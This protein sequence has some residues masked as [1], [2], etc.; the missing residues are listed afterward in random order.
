MK[1]EEACVT[2]RFPNMEKA[3]EI[4]IFQDLTSQIRGY[5][6]TK[7]EIGMIK[8]EKHSGNY[9]VY[10]LIGT[11]KSVY[12]GQSE[13]GIKRIEDHTRNKNFWTHCL[14]FVT[15]NN[16]FDKTSIDYLEN[17]FIKKFNQSE[18]TLENALVMDK[19]THT[20]DFET[21]RYKN[22][23]KHIERLLLCNGIKIENKTELEKRVGL[24]NNNITSHHFKNKK[25]TASIVLLDGSFILKEGSE[26]REPEELK[27]IMS[28]NNSSE[29]TNYMKNNTIKKI[30]QLIECGMAKRENGKIVTKEDIIFGS[31]SGPAR[32][33]TG[34]PDNGWDYWVGLSEFRDKETFV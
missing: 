34:N 30:E 16:T 15:D 18:Y 26:L 12:I 8:Q 29:N 3:D 1:Y 33:I 24:K 11:E 23:S 10:F 19:T 7:S 5:Y 22:L 31:P 13:N 14:M 2:F 20:N 4:K 25:G 27:Q 17:H 28:K 9:C 6:F 32:L 21:V